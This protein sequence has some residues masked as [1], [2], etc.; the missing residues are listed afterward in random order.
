MVIEKTSTLPAWQQHSRNLMTLKHSFQSPRKWHS[1]LVWSWEKRL[2]GHWC[3][4]EAN[5]LWDPFSFQ[6]LFFCLFVCFYTSL[7]SAWGLENRI[8]YLKMH[9]HLYLHCFPWDLFCLSKKANHFELD[10]IFYWQCFL[11]SFLHS[12]FF[13]LC[14]F[15]FVFLF[16]LHHGIQT[17]R[18]SGM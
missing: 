14:L 6:I 17:Q 3:L 5:Q 18:L 15:V 2:N 4:R 11:P 10:V 8:L 1:V 13:V 16:C 12:F 7:S 9:Q